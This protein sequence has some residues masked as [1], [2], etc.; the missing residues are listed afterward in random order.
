MKVGI[1]AIKTTVIYDILLNS[2]LGI[3]SQS[4]AVILSFL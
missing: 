1:Q 2:K 3:F 4:Y